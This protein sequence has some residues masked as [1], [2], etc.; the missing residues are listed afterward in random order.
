MQL[1][2]DLNDPARAGKA[3]VELFKQ[4]TGVDP[5][6]QNELQLAPAANPEAAA[7]PPVNPR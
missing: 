2:S 5:V 1:T 4:E 6:E 3:I 7:E